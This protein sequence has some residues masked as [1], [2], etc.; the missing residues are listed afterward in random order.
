MNAKILSLFLL[1]VSSSLAV[2]AGLWGWADL[3]AQNAYFYMDKWQKTK[4]VG[5]LNEWRTAYQSMR[6]ARK[7]NP[8]SVDY[9]IEMGQLYEWSATFMTFRSDRQQSLNEAKKYYQLA[10]EH[11]P[12][13]PHAWANYVYVKILLNESDD[14]LYTAIRK[15]IEYGPW[16]KD[17]QKKMFVASLMEWD[18]LPLSLQGSVKTSMQKWLGDKRQSMGRFI[19]SKAVDMDR[20]YVVRLALAGMDN[21]EKFEKY[22]KF[23]N[24]LTKKKSGYCK[25]SQC[26][27][28]PIKRFDERFEV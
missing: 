26:V 6:K 24:R 12:T 18:K 5:G 25:E 23:L 15:T 21:K 13:W 17:A 7:F 2:T 3:N 14:N 16:I 20:T 19:I 8:Y 4:Q 1:I 28:I 27:R 11:R 22:E 9:M 10:V